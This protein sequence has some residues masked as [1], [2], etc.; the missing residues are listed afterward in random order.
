MASLVRWDPFVDLL[1]LPR[2]M[3]R[4]I[5]WPRSPLRPAMR[6]SENQLLVPTMDVMH[7]NGDMVVRVE[8]PGI[9][10]DDIDISV[11]DNMLIISGERTEEHET[12]DEDY[13]VKESSWGSF[14]RRIALP[15]GIDPATIHAEFTNGVLEVTIPKTGVLEEPMAHHIAI[16]AGTRH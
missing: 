4:L 15:K 8:L 5:D 10:Q 14:E 16:G 7:R 2:E 9:K 13:V 11:S 1:A 3:D 6:E 12:R